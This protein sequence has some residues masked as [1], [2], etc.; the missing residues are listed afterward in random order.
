[1]FITDQHRNQITT[2]LN[3]MERQFKVLQL[4][5]PHSQAEFTDNPV[6]QAA[7]ERALHI[8]L[9]G[10]T[11]IGNLIIDALIMRDPASYE[12][13][14]TIL[15]EEGVFEKAFSDRFMG[16]VRFRKALAHEYLT[17]TTEAVYEAVQNYA[18]DF[19]TLRDSIAKYVGL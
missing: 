6:L 1:M 8:A 17:L 15:T 18:D 5:K 4:L 11:D 3:E 9:E 2:Y 7:G 16:A 10:L 14:L 19:P 12:D 13:I